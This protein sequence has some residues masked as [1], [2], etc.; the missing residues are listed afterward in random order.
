MHTLHL[1]VYKDTCRTAVWCLISGDDWATGSGDLET[2][3]KLGHLRLQQSL[4]KW[5]KKKKAHLREGEHCYEIGALTI[6]MIGTASEPCLAIKAAECGTFLEFC[7]DELRRCVDDVR[8]DFKAQA[9]AL[10]AVLEALV[11]LRD[12]MRWGLVY[13][14]QTS[15]SV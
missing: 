3:A 13:F 12:E 1:G 10:L 7:R 14:C 6:G 11:S 8:E 2:L 4:T 5:Y 9:A 15:R